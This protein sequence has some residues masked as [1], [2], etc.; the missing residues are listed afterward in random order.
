VSTTYEASTAL[1]NP[2]LM[3]AT[4]ALRDESR[5]QVLE[6]AE[7]RFPDRATLTVTG[8]TE[9]FDRKGNSCIE[10]RA[11]VHAKNV[12]ALLQSA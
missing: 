3:R 4:E 6:V 10:C 11:A 9:F 5:R 1:P 7:L 8:L 2:Y 12:S